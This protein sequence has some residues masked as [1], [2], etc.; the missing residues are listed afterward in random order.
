MN[1]TNN[2]IEESNYPNDPIIKYTNKGS[3][4]S[5]FIYEVIDIGH[6]PE[7]YK[8]TRGN[9]HPIPDNYKIKTTFVKNTITCSINYEK[10]I[11]V[12]QIDWVKGVD[13]FNVISTKSAT[14]ATDLFLKVINFYIIIFE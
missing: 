14:E 9:S 2:S 1:P 5:N 8:T 13:N 6:Y 10:N 12:Y 3:A 7:N 11:P 4:S